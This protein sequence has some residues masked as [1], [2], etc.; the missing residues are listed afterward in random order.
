MPEKAV[1]E[2]ARLNPGQIERTGDNKVIPALR[3]CRRNR[4]EPVDHPTGRF[5]AGTH[6]LVWDGRDAGG[7]KVASGAYMAR[8][9]FDGRS[10]ARKIV[11]VR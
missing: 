3:P 9:E 7:R 10:T 5:P 8:L 2:Q 4:P 6:R 1:L 11:L